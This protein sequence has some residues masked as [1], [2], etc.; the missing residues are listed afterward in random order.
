MPASAALSSGPCLGAPGRLG[1]GLRPG[2][3]GGAGSLSFGI[4]CPGGASR[5]SG[6]SAAPGRGSGRCRPAA[7]R[8]AGTDLEL[9]VAHAV[10]EAVQRAHRR[11]AVDLALEVVHAAVARADEP[12]G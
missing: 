5:A 9:A 8:E 1:A 10:V 2:G 3:T 4:S 12:L 7:D 11:T 6:R